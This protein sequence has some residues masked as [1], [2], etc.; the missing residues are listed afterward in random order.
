M[1]TTQVALTP[2][3]QASL[4][5]LLKKFADRLLPAKLRNTNRNGL[6]LAD[7]NVSRGLPINENTLYDAAKEIYRELDWEIKP[8]KLVLEERETKPPSV[9]SA[10]ASEGRFVA[11]VRA[12][13]AADAQAK[14]DAASIQ[15]AK[16]LIEGYRPTKHTR[17]ASSFDHREIAEK[18]AEWTAALLQA[19][20]GKRNLQEWVKAL[21]AT[22]EKRYTDRERASERL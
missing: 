5:A 1:A 13:E 12:G 10:Q 11:K 3:Q 20:A 22:I 16:N 21:A 4:N 14:A 9:E 8:Q 2:Q 17:G 6:L 18:T 15:Q 7:Y 19:I